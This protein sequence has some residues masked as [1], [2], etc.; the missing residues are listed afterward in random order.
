MKMPAPLRIGVVPYLNARPLV[1][2]LDR[3]ADL[4][5]DRRAPARLAE[6]LWKGDLDAAL[7][8][9]FALGVRHGT[10][11]VQGVAIGSD[12][13][14]R[15]VLLCCRRAPGEIRRWAPDPD[16]LSSNAL[17][18]ILLAE[19]Y[20]VNPTTASREEADAVLVIG[21]PA[22]K[23]L[24]GSWHE[25]LDLGEA[26]RALT[27][28]PFVYAVWAIREGVDA[29]GLPDLLREAKRRGVA[30]LAS[31]DSGLM[32]GGGAPPRPGAQRI[33]QA[34]D[35]VDGV[36]PP[37]PSQTRHGGRVENERA[38]GWRAALSPAELDYLRHAVRYDL[39]EREREGLG[40]FLEKA[41]RRGLLPRVPEPA[42]I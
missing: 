31:P 19:R 12:G 23:G 6:A 26:W 38:P 40:L 20:G 37:R 11:A 17:A 36:R 4:R 18:S 7:I 28:K 25:V 2:G 16:S 5:L 22:L 24:G 33:P 9:A 42:W 34:A 8:P 39:G 35:A 15:S 14:V 29:P 10:R 41:R 3:H 1:D 32:P 30:A 21:D 13:P 27:D